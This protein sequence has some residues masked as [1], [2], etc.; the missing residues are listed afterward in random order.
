MKEVQ[1]ADVPALG[2]QITKKLGK[3]WA[4]TGTERTGDEQQPEAS[5][6][7]HKLI[8]KQRVLT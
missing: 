5:N 2:K 3:A 1:R 8:R 4:K 7:V 6:R